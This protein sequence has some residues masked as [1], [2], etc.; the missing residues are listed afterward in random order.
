ML[1]ANTISLLSSHDKNVSTSMDEPY[2]PT[3]KKKTSPSPKKNSCYEVKQE[4]KMS[5][6]LVIQQEESTVRHTAIMSKS[7]KLFDNYDQGDLDLDEVGFFDDEL[8]L[9]KWVIKEIQ[10][11]GG[12]IENIDNLID[13]IFTHHEGI[14]IEGTW[15]DWEQLEPVFAEMKYREED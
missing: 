10:E 13:Y 15:Y 3:S 9:L 12:G 7:V 5:N 4:N 1:W 2:Q 11:S 8:E 6:R 14:E